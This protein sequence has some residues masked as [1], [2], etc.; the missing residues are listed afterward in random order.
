MYDPFFSLPRI[1]VED[2]AGRLYGSGKEK[3]P[4]Y[5]SGITNRSMGTIPCS[6]LPSH[7]WKI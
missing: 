5:G 7:L 3:F 6:N 1:H 4:Y 2:I